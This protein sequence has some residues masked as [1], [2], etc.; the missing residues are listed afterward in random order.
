M[1]WLHVLR[2]AYSVSLHVSYISC[3]KWVGRV[4]KFIFFTL[5][6][7]YVLAQF[8]AM[9][10]RDH[11]VLS[12]SGGG[13]ITCEFTMW[14]C[15]T[16]SLII[17]PRLCV[18]WLQR[19]FPF[20]SMVFIHTRG[21][22]TDNMLHSVTLQHT[23]DWSVCHKTLFCNKFCCGTSCYR[24]CQPDCSAYG[25]HS[26]AWTLWRI[27]SSCSISYPDQINRSP[28]NKWCMS[29]RPVSVWSKLFRTRTVI[30]EWWDN[31][32]PGSAVQSKRM[33]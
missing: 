31:L 1:Q 16:M 5:R 8:L 2:W 30:H 15:F 18:C 9:F 17:W 10:Q 21:W 6:W 33:L 23:F 12:S 29:G 27:T 26:S 19:Q 7:V 20:V 28:I 14:L 22:A 3:N 24:G 4:L 25:F 11:H 13:A 32:K